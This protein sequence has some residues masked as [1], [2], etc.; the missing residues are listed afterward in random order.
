MFKVPEEIDCDED[1]D[2]CENYDECDKFEKA[3]PIQI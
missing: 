1:C 2:E 3:C